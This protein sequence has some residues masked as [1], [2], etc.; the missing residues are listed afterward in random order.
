VP[1]GAIVALFA[2][3]PSQCMTNEKQDPGNFPG[4]LKAPEPPLRV[5]LHLA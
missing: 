4:I 2:R 5:N 3:S 1:G